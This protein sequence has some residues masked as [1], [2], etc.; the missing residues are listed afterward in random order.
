MISIYTCFDSMSYCF[1]V[2]IY[3]Y[4]V[5]VSY[6]FS[7]VCLVLIMIVFVLKASVESSAVHWSEFTLV[8]DDVNK[9]IL[10]VMCFYASHLHFVFR[11]STTGCGVDNYLMNSTNKTLACIF[12]F[13]FYF[14]YGTERPNWFRPLE[15]RKEGNT[16]GTMSLC[17]R[18]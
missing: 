5:T 7:Y 6:F 8:G 3:I 14:R 13:Q 17:K 16:R 12:T 10:W 9:L 18:T 11:C 2:F 4:G 1:D 15:Q